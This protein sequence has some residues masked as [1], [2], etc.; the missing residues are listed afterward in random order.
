MDIPPDPRLARRGIESPASPLLAGKRKANA[1]PDGKGRAQK[2]GKAQGREASLTPSY[3]TLGGSPLNTPTEYQI[4]IRDTA[5]RSRVH[6]SLDTLTKEIVNVTQKSIAKSEAKSLWVEAEN[7]RAS[8]KGYYDR[9]TEASD[10]DESARTKHNLGDRQKQLYDAETR[11]QEALF[12]FANAIAEQQK[13]VTDHNSYVTLEEFNTTVDALRA[14]IEAARKGNQNV[15]AEQPILHEWPIVKKDLNDTKEEVR[16]LQRAGRAIEN[17][18]ALIREDTEENGKGPVKTRLRRLDQHVNNLFNLVGEA[19]AKVT[20][21]ERVFNLEKSRGTTENKI[22]D[23][24]KGLN[25]AQQSITF[26]KQE[27]KQTQQSIA[28][29]KQ[30]LKTLTQ[31]LEQTQNVTSKVEGSLKANSTVLNRLS[32]DVKAL[33]TSGGGLAKDLVSMQTPSVEPGLTDKATQN[34]R[35][36]EVASRLQKIEERLEDIDNENAEK[37]TMLDETFASSAQQYKKDLVRLESEFKDSLSELQKQTLPGSATK[38]IV[39]KFEQ[40]QTE[41]RTRLQSLDLRGTPKPETHRPRQINGFNLA[42][43]TTSDAAYELPTCHMRQQN[44]TAPARSNP[45]SSR[46]STHH[47]NQTNQITPAPTDQSKLPSSEFHLEN[48]N[49]RLDA[50]TRHVRHLQRLQDNLTTQDVHQA[51]LDQIGEQYP[52]LKRYQHTCETLS[53]GLSELRNRVCE[54]ERVGFESSRGVE[55]LRRQGVERGEWITLA[56]LRLGGIESKVQGVKELMTDLQ[57]EGRDRGEWQVKVEGRLQN[58][59]QGFQGAEEQLERQGKDLQKQERG[60]EKHERDLR[61]FG[62]LQE[63]TAENVREQLEGAVSLVR[64]IVDGRLGE[65]DLGRV[66]GA[67]Q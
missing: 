31:R 30:E 40:L 27:V 43:G 35:D 19:S 53:H 58:M 29:I 36:N 21:T 49:A 7:F 22:L 38:D 47:A 28:S 48:L 60:L 23:V 13:P 50:L 25:Q 9:W 59:E 6:Q 33:K 52:H 17:D 61:T 15:T 46:N 57:T 63:V 10:H 65:L 67:R 12:E 45:P 11:K 41:V 42:E 24:R 55:E 34:N 32:D 5:S 3:G 44:G 2:V 56:D 4:R 64:D 62:T 18:V 66:G 8:V 37:E 51:M 20:L 54:F 14:D 26:I 1:S 39:E 16:I